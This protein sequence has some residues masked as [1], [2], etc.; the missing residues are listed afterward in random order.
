M[1]KI[2]RHFKDDISAKIILDLAKASKG[3]KKT[4]VSML[5]KSAL[6]LHKA[7]KRLGMLRGLNPSQRDLNSKEL[8]DVLMDY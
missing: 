7:Q 2:E 3:A 8:L 1:E 4:Q 6:A 5:Q